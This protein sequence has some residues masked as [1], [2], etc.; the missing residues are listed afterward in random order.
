[1]KTQ[2]HSKTLTRLLMTALT[3]AAL[4]CGSSGCTALTSPISG[5][6]AHRLPPQ[7][8]APPKN[9]L[10]PIDISRLRQEPPREYLVDSGDVLGI[11]IEGVLGILDE[12]PPVHMPKEGSDLPPSIGF[13]IPVREDGTLALP[14]VPAIPVR[15]LTLAQVENV[16]R[17]AYTI[18]QQILQQGKDRIIV[19]LMDK[20]K[21]NV[22]VMRQDGFNQMVTA[23]GANAG[24]G[25]AAASTRGGVVALEA[26][27]NDVLHALAETGGLPGLDAKNE[28]KVYRSSLMDSQ[29]RDAFVREYFSLPC[30][31]CMCRPPLPDDPAVL[32]IP[33]RLPPGMTPPFRTQDIILEEGDIVVVE[34]REREVFYTGGLLGGGEHPLPRDYDL[35]VLGAMAMVGRGIASTGQGG[36]G[37]GGYGGNIGAGNIG[38]VAPGNLFIL[39]KTP[40]DGQIIIAVDLNRAINNPG[41]RP[42]VQPGDTLILQYKPIEEVL[43][44]GIGTFFTYGIFQLLQNDN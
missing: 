13:P 39:R 41:A 22:V 42:L 21:Y 18:D 16:I 19:T 31:P 15:G 25:L 2:P 10:L 29:K 40:C 11:F 3:A 27:K 4:C 1:M 36:G 30:E 20:R 6:P 37:G 24:P 43:N 28:V 23:A 12:A 8:L 7:F 5:I 33:L 26:Y 9:N 32:R 14:L 38:G 44:F 34:G 17:R 35:D